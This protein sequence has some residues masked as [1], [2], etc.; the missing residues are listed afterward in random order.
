ME[1]DQLCF[2]FSSCCL[3]PKPSVR[4]CHT[5]PQKGRPEA[6]AESCDG[7]RLLLERGG[8]TLARS[9]VHDTINT[10]R[11][12]SQCFSQGPAHNGASSAQAHSGDLASQ[13]SKHQ[14]EKSKPP[15]CVPFSLPEP[16]VNGLRGSCPAV[17]LGMGLFDAKTQTR[18]RKELNERR[19]QLWHLSKQLQILLSD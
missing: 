13:F 1:K 9:D 15:S 17:S 8:V 14:V 18:T 3:G 19:L 12:L 10:G 4:R 7:S 16:S 2:K 6:Q 5:N 11:L